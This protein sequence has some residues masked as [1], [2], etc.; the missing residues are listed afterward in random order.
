MREKRNQQRVALEV[1]IADKDN[2]ISG[3]TKNI[4]TGGCFM[5]KPEDFD[6]LPIG[7][8]APFFLEIPGGY[9]YTEIVG[10]VTHHGKNGDGMGICFKTTHPGIISIIENF[11]HTHS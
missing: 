5:K 3:F 7:S 4:S 8:K 2:H 9:A 6:L 11:L 10:I 1:R